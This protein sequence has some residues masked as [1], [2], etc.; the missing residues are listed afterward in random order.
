MDIPYLGY[1]ITWYGIKPDP[2]KVLGIMDLRLPNTTTEARALIVMFQYYRYMWPRRSG[3]LVPLT[4]ADRGPNGRKKNC[5]DSME[6][7]FNEIKRMVFSETLFNYLYWKIPF[8]VHIYASDK[9]FGAVISHNN[10]PIQFLSSILSK[11]QSNY[12]TT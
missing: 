5:N 7:S 8:T 9:Q 2:K 3:I 10:E 12:T 4:E 11:P 1:V 6:Y